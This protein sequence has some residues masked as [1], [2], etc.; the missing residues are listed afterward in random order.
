M[1]EN[2]P[3]PRYVQTFNNPNAHKSSAALIKQIIEM[4]GHF[5]LF[6]PHTKKLLMGNA[7]YEGQHLTTI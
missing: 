6:S 2:F 7:Y 1:Y 4:E 5:S 3:A